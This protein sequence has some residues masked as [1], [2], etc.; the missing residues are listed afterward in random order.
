MY[1]LSNCQDDRKAVWSMRGKPTAPLLFH[2]FDDAV[3]YIETI[4]LPGYDQQGIDGG[5]DWEIEEAN[6][7]EI[8]KEHGAFWM[9]KAPGT[10]A[11]C[12]QTAASRN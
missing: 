9:W 10:Y 1:C 8:M 2:S 6:L 5:E 11:Y 4:V 12:G 3:A 7:V